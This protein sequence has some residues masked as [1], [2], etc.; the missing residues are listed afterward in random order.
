MAFTWFSRHA[1]IKPESVALIWDSA[2]VSG[3][4]GKLRNYVENESKKAIEWYFKSKSS[5]SI[6]SRWLR[7]LAI[8]LSTAAGILP[9]A[10]SLLKGKYP[11]LGQLESGLLVSLLL[12]AAAGVI[13]LDHFFG[14]S[15]GWVRYVLTATAIQGALEEFRMDWHLLNA[16][17]STPPTNE[18]VVAM[19]QR[20]KSFR[21]TIA[22]MVLD[23][24][25]A[26]A[27][28]FQS[29]LAQLEKDV[30]ATFEQQRAKV[31][32]EMKIQNLAVRPGGIEVNIP[33]A[34]TADGRTFTVS[35]EGADPPVPVEAVVGSTQWSKIAVPPGQYKVVVRGKRSG[36]D[37]LG[38]RIVKVE[39]G[40]VTTTEIKLPE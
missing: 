5:K 25:K 28:E 10:I 1:D 19:I 36:A 24:T 17:L 16:H 21:T 38:S 4:L 27:A 35:L 11:A 39:S 8:A 32:E 18:Q 40:A 9:I 14:F 31:E 26:W 30:K 29:N 6:W 15:S 12:G 23:E 13:G 33:N 22:N 37:V 3:S 20:A 2:D 7:F 34:L